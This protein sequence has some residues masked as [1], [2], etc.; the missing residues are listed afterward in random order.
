MTDYIN[1]SDTNPYTTADK[2]C[3]AT[4]STHLETVFT[5]AQNEQIRTHKHG[6]WIGRD[7]ITMEGKWMLCF[8]VFFLYFIFIFVLFKDHNKQTPTKK[9]TLDTR[10]AILAQLTHFFFLII[11]LFNFFLHCTTKT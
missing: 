2:W 1:K 11:F 10:Q 6:T 7:E 8:K 9:Q 5:D 4:Y 3:L